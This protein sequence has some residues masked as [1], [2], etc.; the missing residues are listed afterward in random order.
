MATVHV[1]GNPA[2]GGGR[3]PAAVA[4]VVAGVRA[5]GHVAALRTTHGWVASVATLGFAAAVNR[6]ANALRWPR[7]SARYTVAT[8]LRLP[9]LRARRLR[10]EVDG[11]TH[12]VTCTLVAI[13][14]TAYFG[15]GMA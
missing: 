12:E 13:A 3:A 5:A 9:G 10:I 8:L 1:L 2:A 4:E 15:G 7:G 6:R 14:N 11:E